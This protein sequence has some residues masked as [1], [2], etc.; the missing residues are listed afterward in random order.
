MQLTVRDAA[1]LLELVEEEIHRFIE[2]RAI[3]FHEVNE[4]YRFNR[5]ELLAWVAGKADRI[6][7]AVR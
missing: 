3:P 4:Q 7:A 2:E 1:Q 6:A 5:A